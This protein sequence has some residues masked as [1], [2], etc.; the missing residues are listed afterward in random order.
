MYNIDDD[1]VNVMGKGKQLT[2]RHEKRIGSLFISFYVAVLHQKDRV[3]TLATSKPNTPKRNR[4]TS[5]S[6]PLRPY[7]HITQ[8]TSRIAA[9]G[10]C[11]SLIRFC[12]PMSWTPCDPPAPPCRPD[13]WILFTRPHN[14]NTKAFVLQ[15]RQEPPDASNPAIHKHPVWTLVARRRASPRWN[16]LE[17]RTFWAAAPRLLLCLLARVYVRANRRQASS[18]GGLY[19]GEPTD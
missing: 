15:H 5:S 1:H 12:L 16:N 3:Q 10:F 4:S 13:L 18:W 19:K 2:N 9:F 11:T 6:S 17:H 7:Q 14:P 8:I